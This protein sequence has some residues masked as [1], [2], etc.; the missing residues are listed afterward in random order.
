[1]ATRDY[2]RTA[3]WTARALTYFLYA[4]AVINEFILILGFTLV[5]FGA[6]P[7]SGFTQWAYRNLDRVMEPFRGMFTPI[8]LGTATGDVQP[9]LD[10]SILSRC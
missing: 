4:W 9:T 2:K 1:M 7:N 8:P 5:L 3:T 10:T 6:N